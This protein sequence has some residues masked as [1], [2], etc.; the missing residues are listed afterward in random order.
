LTET[1]SAK[2]AAGALAEWAFDAFR[3]VGV[4]AMVILAQVTDNS[5]DSSRALTET[6]VNRKYRTMGKT[7]WSAVKHISDVSFNS[8]NADKSASLAT[9]LPVRGF[10]NVVERDQESTKRYHLAPKP[11]IIDPCVP[12][13]MSG[14]GAADSA[15][16]DLAPGALVCRCAHRVRNLMATEAHGS[17]WRRIGEA[18]KDDLRKVPVDSPASAWRSRYPET[19]HANKQLPEIPRLP[20]DHRDCPDTAV[21]AVIDRGD[22]SR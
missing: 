22:A 21:Q 15:V 8:Q 18:R 11:F 3:L 6:V 13:Q 7:H 14:S 1:G 19:S 9:C 10:S 5:A 2:F 20:H 16:A 4:F 17:Y 12:R